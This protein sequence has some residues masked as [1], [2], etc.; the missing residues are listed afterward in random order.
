MA[1]SLDFV[2]ARGYHLLYLR[3]ANA[4][5]DGVPPDPNVGFAYDIQTEGKSKYMAM[6][7]G[8]QKRF[9]HH[10]AE[11][12]G[13]V[14]EVQPDEESREGGGHPQKLAKWRLR[15]VQLVRNLFEVSPHRQV[16]SSLMM[17]PGVKMPSPKT[18]HSSTLLWAK[19]WPGSH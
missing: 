14:R 18:P 3:N 9:G 11:A 2:Y 15:A 4:P 6:Q 19:R 13:R 1:A 10:P 5:I 17:L 8:F 7:V 12:H 16:V